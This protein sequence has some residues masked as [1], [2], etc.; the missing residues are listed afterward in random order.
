MQTGTGTHA[1]TRT[2]AGTRTFKRLRSKMNLF[3][4][5]KAIVGANLSK[6]LAVGLLSISLL[7]CSSQE[8]GPLKLT[9]KSPSVALINAS[10]RSCYSMKSADGT[11]DV[12]PYYFSIIGP[13]L[14]WN[15]TNATAYIDRIAVILKSSNFEG[16]EQECQ[17]SSTELYANFLNNINATEF[18]IS[19][20]ANVTKDGTC[21]LIC[22]GIKISDPKRSFTATGQAIVTGYQVDTNSQEV[23]AIKSTYFFNVVYTAL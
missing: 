19:P 20:G 9:V 23:T 14:T 21:P 8:D 1:G 4:F 15:N 22:G 3:N 13:K 6:L 5:A 7:S 17:I 11:V 10:A 18:P 16:G 12:S 2:I